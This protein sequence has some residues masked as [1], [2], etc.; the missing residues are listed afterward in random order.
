MAD[1]ATSSCSVSMGRML[2]RSGTSATLLAQNTISSYEMSP[3]SEV[4][5]EAWEKKH[6]SPG[7]TL[8]G[9]CRGNPAPMDI[10]NNIRWTEAS[11][12]RAILLCAGLLLVRF[13]NEALWPTERQAPARFRWAAC[14]GDPSP[15]WTLI[16]HCRGNPA[17]MDIMN[18]IRWT[19][20]SSLRGK[21]Y[22]ILR[23][24]RRTGS[25]P[26]ACEIR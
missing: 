15:G 25:G 16:G 22:H 8:I 12:L 5:W 17:P 23:K 18:N 13:A 20:A 6:L 21:K 11:S 9:H 19:E 2:R 3:R 1:R 4:A 7:W 24:Q 26:S 14:L 10:M